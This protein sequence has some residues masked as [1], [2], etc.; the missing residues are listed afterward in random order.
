MSKTVVQQEATFVRAL[1][2]WRL[3][4]QD[5]LSTIQQRDRYKGELEE[6]DI[7]EGEL[8]Y[9]QEDTLMYHAVG[10]VLQPTDLSTTRTTVD[11]RK[12]YLLNEIQRLEQYLDQQGQQQKE[13]RYQLAEMQKKLPHIPQSIVDL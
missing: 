4:N 8:V 13:R 7:L 1:Q 12:T 6:L 9:L 11:K 2:H 10:P 5:I 3:C